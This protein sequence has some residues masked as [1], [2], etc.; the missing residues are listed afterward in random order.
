MVAGIPRLHCAVPHQ[1]PQVAAQRAQPPHPPLY[2]RRARP[3]RAEGLRLPVPRAQGGEAEGEGEENGRAAAGQQGEAGGAPE[4]HERHEGAAQP[5]GHLPGLPPGPVQPLQGGQALGQPPARHRRPQDPPG[6]RALLQPAE[7]LPPTCGGAAGH[8]EQPAVGRRAQDAGA[9]HAHAQGLLRGLGRGG[10]VPAGAEAGQQG[11]GDR[12]R[13]VAHAPR[14]HLPRAPQRAL[15]GQEQPVL[16]LHAGGRAGR[17][18][19]G[20]RGQDHVPRRDDALGHRDQDAQVAPQEL[21]RVLL[22]QGGCQLVHG[23]PKTREQG[24]GD[25]VR[26]DAARPRHLPPCPRPGHLRGQGPPVQVLPG[27]A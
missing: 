10:M 5:R 27:R 1:G 18:G 9:A 16:S 7:G 4:G 12:N 17:A 22:G 11:G 24:R 19:A 15:P 2:H 14:A 13:R 25:A 23:E 21:L 3:L 26:S 20:V 8:D 6:A